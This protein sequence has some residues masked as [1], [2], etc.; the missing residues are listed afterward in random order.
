M[1]YPYS[2]QQYKNHQDIIY[3]DQQQLTNVINEL[4]NQQ[5][6]ITSDSI[7]ELKQQLI[8]ASLGKAF[9]IQGGDCTEIFNT[10]IKVSQS[11]VE[12]LNLMGNI[13]TQQLKLPVIKIGRIAGQFAK[14]RT[15]LYDPINQMDNYRGDMINKHNN[16]KA[17]R[18][19]NPQYLLS[20]F[21]HAKNIY[22]NIHGVYTS[23]EAINLYYESALTK[24][25]NNGIYYNLSAHL[26]WVGIRTK[27]I[28]SAQIEYLAGINNPVAI[29][30]ENNA[31]LD[32]LILIIKKLNPHNLAGKICMVTRIGYQYVTTFLPKLI[33]Y[34]QQYQLNIIWMCDP[35]HGNTIIK[36][37]TKNRNTKDIYQEVKL[38]KQIHTEHNNILAG[39]HLECSSEDILECQDNDN[40]ITQPALVDPRLNKTQALKL[41]NEF[42]HQ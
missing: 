34:L 3:H 8:Q 5:P 35:M 31:S 36:Q 40:T 16:N 37:Q 28:D 42:C 21:K 9:I 10:P 4:T 14:P 30:V 41:I 6:F 32:E 11:N 15:Q 12:L 25:I 33:Q 2:W 27:Q 17:D 26:L 22:S 29:K 39:L 18:V 23:H 20:A 7:D 24:Q 1:W 13:I 38:T 19:P